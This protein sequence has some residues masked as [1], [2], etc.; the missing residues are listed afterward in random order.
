[1]PRPPCGTASTRDT[2]AFAAGDGDRA[3]DRLAAI[4]APTVPL[5]PV[6]RDVWS[7]HVL[8]LPGPTPRVAGFVDFH[9]AG[10]DSP[11]ADV[12]RL[13]GSWMPGGAAAGPLDPWAA[14]LAAYEARRPLAP[15]ERR[16]IPVLHASG[17]VF[18]LDNWFRWVLEEGRTFPD[19]VTVVGR[20]DRLLAAL[21]QALQELGAI[22]PV[23]GTGPI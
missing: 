21:P 2:E 11:V 5:Q 22:A 19:P 6:L 7:A 18:G 9:A 15:A 16:A 17:V 13:L 1:M 8:F 3:L 14:A 20:V 12:A 10:I 4:E 23:S